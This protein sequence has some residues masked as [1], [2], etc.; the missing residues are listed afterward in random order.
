MRTINE[1]FHQAWIQRGFGL[2]LILIFL[3]LGKVDASPWVVGYER[4]HGD[5]PSELGGA[6]LYSELGCANC[7][8]GSSIQIPR[9]GPS[10]DNI[11]SR[12]RYEWVVDFLK[13]PT[14]HHM[15]SNMP[16]LLHGASDEDIE[17]IT[18]YL[19]TIG[20]GLNLKPSRHAN[21]VLG[22]E[23]YHQKGCVACHDPNEKDQ[24]VE[25]ADLSH[26]YPLPDLNSK[27]NL[28][29][30]EHFLINTSQYR[31]DGRMPHME[32]GRDG[33]INVAAYLLDFEGSDPNTVS[34]IQS[35]PKANEDQII[36]GKTLVE[37]ASCSA[38]HD[39]PGIDPPPIITLNKEWKSDTHC[40]SKSTQKDRPFYELS[41]HQRESL[42]IYLS[43]SEIQ[44][45]IDGSQTLK[46][47]NC[48]ACHD[49]DGVGGPTILADPFFHGEESL[50]DSGRLPPPLTG[51]GHKLKKGWLERVLNGDQKTRVRPYLKTVMPAYPNQAKVL[52]DILS[53]ADNNP[54][55]KPLTTGTGLLESGRKLLG[56]QGGVNC[57][58]CH[59]WGDQ[60]SLGIPGLD[61]SS[62]D[63]RLNPEW[64]RS[65]LLNPPSYRPGTL[66]PSLWPEGKS[67]IP[68]I[69]NGNTEK[70]I[71]AIWEFI[72][73]G[74]GDPEGFSDR[75]SGQFVLK[76]TNRPIIQRTFLKGVGT[77]AILVGFPGGIHLAY[78]GDGARPAQIWRGEFFDAYSTWFMRMAPFENPLG[79]DI[80][81]F[82]NVDSQR[83]FRGYKLDKKGIP[84]FLFQDSNR[85][86][87][88]RIEVRDRSLIRSLTWNKGTAPEVTHPDGLILEETRDTKKL[89]IQYRWK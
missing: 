34:P 27:T 51:I 17:S 53:K 25:E 66:M 6:I 57:I 47:M 23:I 1:H 16:S 55:S 70:Q 88:E 74:L 19:S 26:S 54:N 33:A 82:P 3:A 45:D 22:R 15:G 58:T 46:A 77:K 61:I 21:G 62:L 32:L 12:V 76:P 2:Y 20:K 41:N 7:H 42:T 38:C 72:A 64:F 14:S 85:L 44:K 87:E 84:T 75:G 40:I 89:R 67:T 50:G 71:A 24:L 60:K 28:L 80:V 79:K 4:F 48:Y 63:Q 83:R 39:L 56:T 36:R 78:D 49:R 52:A 18:A 10:L 35:W 29:A 31:P 43:S 5:E 30:L 81:T 86:V 11:S 37:K 59:H 9:R 68:A 13:N 73:N 8:G 65:Y 69:L